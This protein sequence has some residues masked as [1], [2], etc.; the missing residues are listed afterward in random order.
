MDVDPPVPPP[1]PLFQSIHPHTAAPTVTTFDTLFYDTMSPRRAFESPTGPQHKK[2][3]SHSPTTTYRVEQE[4]SSSP[5]LPSS[6]SDRR[7]DRIASANVF[8]AKPS[9]IG[10]GAPSASKKPR[11]PALSAMIQPSGASA[12]SAFAI[13]TSACIGSDHQTLPPTRRA[14]SAVISP[15]AMADHLSEDSSFESSADVS[16]PAQA[17]AQ[18]QK[19]K[20]IRRCDGTEDFRP[21]TG[22]TAMVTKESPANKLPSPGWPGFGDN[23]AHGKILPCHRVSEDGLMRITPDTVCY[24]QLKFTHC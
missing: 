16:S 12:H 20:T 22:A 13:M 5:A 1:A 2:R 18:R 7:L 24:A 4:A 19:L 15:T 11:R 8:G 10:L 9:L 21:L 23:E 17:Y 14:F 6:P 3:R